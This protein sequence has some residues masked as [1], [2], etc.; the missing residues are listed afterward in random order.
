[1]SEN[2]KREMLDPV[3]PLLGT[4]WA[5]PAERDGLTGM[6]GGIRRKIMPPEICFRKVA[7]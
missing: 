3:A 1:M 2:A 7:Q 4:T 5:V 6:A